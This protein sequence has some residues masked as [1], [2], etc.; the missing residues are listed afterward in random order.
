MRFSNLC[1]R[2]FGIPKKDNS[3]TTSKRIEAP[4]MTRMP[5]R[6]LPTLKS[7]SSPPT[8]NSG[9]CFGAPHERSITRSYVKLSEIQQRLVIAPINQETGNNDETPTQCSAEP[10][11]EEIASTPLLEY[12]IL[13]QAQKPRAAKQAYVEDA[14]AEEAAQQDTA[15]ST[16]RPWILLLTPGPATSEGHAH[17][18][19]VAESKGDNQPKA[20]QKEETY[21]FPRYAYRDSDEHYD[22]DAEDDAELKR[23][24]VKASEEMIDD[25][26][27]G[28]EVSDLEDLLANFTTKEF[29]MMQEDP[30]ANEAAQHKPAEQ[31][32]RLEESS[33]SE[34]HED[35]NEYHPPKT[36]SAGIPDLQKETLGGP[37]LSQTK[38]LVRHSHAPSLSSSISPSYFTPPST[39]AHIK[40]GQEAEED[41]EPVAEFQARIM[42]ENKLLK[43]ENDYL[44]QEREV[45]NNLYERLQVSHHNNRQYLLA[46]DEQLDDNDQE[47]EALT[48]Q[49]HQK[50]KELDKA[51]SR[52]M[53]SRKS[54]RVAQQAIKT[55]IELK[56]TRAQLENTEI[57]LKYAKAAGK[58]RYR[59]IKRKSDDE[60]DDLA[61]QTAGVKRRMVDPDA[62]PEP[63]EEDTDSEEL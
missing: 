17:T 51:K 34:A 8:L 16:R 42:R 1:S 59:G 29:E 5:K 23:A 43:D 18:E 54:V 53:R 3:K 22:A 32:A 45:A 4:S 20:E 44:Y 30:A 2:L 7:A 41:I 37:T 56:K 12:Q 13:S 58:T 21:L 61:G 39:P 15:T 63:M 52:L 36:S 35:N 57:D 60:E 26:K 49:L 40:D 38:A 55:R 28:S 27:A 24:N 11:S 31:E 19:Y 62:F 9:K 46:A 50:Q 48:G 47:L 14:V 25:G 33:I 6:L 10:N